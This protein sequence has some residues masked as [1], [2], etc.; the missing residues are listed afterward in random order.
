MP[1][2][3]WLGTR[4]EKIRKTQKNLPKARQALEVAELIRQRK[5]KSAADK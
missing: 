2:I 4:Q 3:N 1:D 5:I